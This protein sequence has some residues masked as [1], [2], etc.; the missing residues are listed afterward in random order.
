M[1]DEVLWKDASLPS[2]ILP[3]P[4]P[5]LAANANHGLSWRERQLVIEARDEW[6]RR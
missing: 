1:L 5:R 3:V 2:D 6:V 4:P